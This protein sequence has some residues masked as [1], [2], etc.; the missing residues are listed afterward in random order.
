[1]KVSVIIPTYCPG[2]YLWKCLES[3]KAQTF[4]K[5]DF[6]IILV[7]NGC[8]DPYRSQIQEYLQ[9][10]MHDMHITFIQT[11]IPG[12]SNA[13][14]I[15]LDTAK[16]EFVT[17]IDDDDYVSPHFLSGLYKAATPDTISLC[18]P[19]AFIDGKTGFVPYG[20]TK[21]FDKLSP[22]RETNIFKARK[23]FSGPC[24]KLI[25]LN[26]IHSRK[27]DTRFV[28][29][30]DS[31][32]MFLISDRIHKVTFSPSDSIYYRRYRE[33]SASSKRRKF[34]EVIK[35]DILFI[36]EIIRIYL[37]SPY[38]YNFFFFITRLLGRIKGS[39]VY[40]TIGR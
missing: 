27:F 12:V 29:H 33:N 17:F 16:G 10:Y 38:S 14:N 34:L 28:N 7:L 4:Q 36:K 26:L 13:R 37:T 18:R 20:I 31:I 6:E 39:I 23:F 2:T 3:L 15:A 30:E 11:D 35:T 9:A 19:L 22:K 40:F 32:F 24:M 8:D 5:N 25:P 1:M 21:V